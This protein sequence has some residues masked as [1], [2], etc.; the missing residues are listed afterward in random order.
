MIFVF[1]SA[2]QNPHVLKVEYSV[3]LKKC[4]LPHLQQS[5]EKSQAAK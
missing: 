5:T 4:L 1:F 3:I 2:A